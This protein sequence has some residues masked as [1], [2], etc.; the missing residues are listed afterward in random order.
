[1]AVSSAGGASWVRIGSASSL[2][3]LLPRT[4]IGWFQPH[5]TGVFNN[6]VGKFDNDN[7]WSCFVQ[8]DG[9]LGAYQGL[10]SGAFEWAT[11]DPI[12]VDTSWRYLAW[13]IDMLATP[14]VQAYSGTLTTPVVAH[15]MTASAS[16]T[17]TM[18]DDSAGNLDIAGLGV[19]PVSADGNT[20][21]PLILG[22][23]L[24]IDQ[25][26]LLRRRT[27][28]D[29]ALHVSGAVYAGEWLTISDL[30]DLS[31]AGNNG[32]NNG[33]TTVADP[34]LPGPPTRRLRL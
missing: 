9:R 11:T 34:D 3:N 17:G 13:V 8:D 30:A 15:A 1:M 31:G 33:C 5:T 7:G 22:G 12:V 10:T 24:T 18:W 21:R 23:T 25:I 16:S 14:Q 19:F 27:A 4:V 20:R 28:R 2:D 29:V 32:V 26:E 6:V